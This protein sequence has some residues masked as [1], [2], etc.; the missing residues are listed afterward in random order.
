MAN[1]KPSE[2]STITIGLRSR[3]PKRAWWSMIQTPSV[4][5]SRLEIV[6]SATIGENPAAP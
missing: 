1:A 6:N 5:C 4:K 3:L 2:R